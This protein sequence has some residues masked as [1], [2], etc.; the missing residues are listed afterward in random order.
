MP[1]LQHPVAAKLCVRPPKVLEVLYHHAK[2]G[3]ARISPVEFL[4]VCRFVRH[5][6]AVTLPVYAVYVRQVAPIVRREF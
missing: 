2:F 5:A 6:H 1:N 4:S 3:G